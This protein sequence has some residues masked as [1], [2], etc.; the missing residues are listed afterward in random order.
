M[1]RLAALMM[2]GAGAA[3]LASNSVNAGA[4]D[5]KMRWSA[6]Q[7]GACKWFPAIKVPAAGDD[8]KP[9]VHV[10][11]ITYKAKEL[12]EFFVIGDGDSDVDVVVKD[13]KGAI[14]AKDVDPPA[15][16]GGGSDLCYCRWTP[17]EEEEFT[18]IILNQGRVYNVV[19]AG[20]N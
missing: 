1:K 20:C 4:K 5:G 14:V 16:E 2:I 7:T 17:K 9:G 6:K 18:I 13:S 15:E 11:K 8:K 10:L 3:L 12:A 19:Q